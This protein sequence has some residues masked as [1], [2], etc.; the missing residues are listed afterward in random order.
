MPTPSLFPL[1][2]KAQSGGEAGE[3]TVFIETIEVEVLDIIDVE[4]IEF[5]DPEVLP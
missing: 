1:F 5:V 2:L 4:V 3:G